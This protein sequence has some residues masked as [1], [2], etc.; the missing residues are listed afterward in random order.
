[1]YIYSFDCAIKNLGVCCISIDLDWEEKIKKYT[2]DLY[3]LY[4]LDCTGDQFMAK[5]LALLKL[6]DNTLEERIKLIWINVFDLIPGKK[7]E[8][9]P[10]GVIVKKLKY[11]LHFL[12]ETL[13]KP[14][15]VLIEYQMN[16]NDKARGVSRFIEE[17]FTPLSELE[18][19]ITIGL[20]SYPLLTSDIPKA[21]SSVEVHIV[22]PTLKNAYNIDP[23]ELGDYGTYIKDYS[24]Y[25]SNK[26]HAVC[27]FT[28]YMRSVK[29]EHQIKNQPTKLDDIA[30]SFMMAY[31]WC[32]KKQLI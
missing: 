24:N 22:H 6:I 25:T 9:V 21:E 15:V 16:V 10:F 5:A 20:E 7:L 8:E 26:K 3:A 30:D 31:A 2:K 18:S 17:Y 19:D 1:M 4:E 29:K 14:D 11:V 28:Y 13:P 23:S 12:K 32:R 27:N